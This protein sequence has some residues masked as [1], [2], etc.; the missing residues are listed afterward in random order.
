ML[1]QWL[2]VENPSKKRKLDGD[3]KKQN[4]KYDK[5]KRERKFDKKWGKEYP[6]LVHSEEEGIMFCKVCKDETEFKGTSKIYM[7]CY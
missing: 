4:K 6:W 2:G 5:E 3:R 7:N 1:S